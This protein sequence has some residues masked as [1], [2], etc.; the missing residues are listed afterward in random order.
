M[1]AA[2]LPF[3]RLL[4]LKQPVTFNHVSNEINTVQGRQLAKLAE[5]WGEKYDKAILKAWAGGDFDE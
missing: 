1:A 5:F 3:K 2:M 4:P